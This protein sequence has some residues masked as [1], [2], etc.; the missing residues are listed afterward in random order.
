MFVFLSHQGSEL[1]NQVKEGDPG[2]RAEGQH[3]LW[4][5]YQ[6]EDAVSLF[7]ALN[8]TFFKQETL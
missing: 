2:R 1:R 8:C 7:S 6:G 3:G 4:E 5:I